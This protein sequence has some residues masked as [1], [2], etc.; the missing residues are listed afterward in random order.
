MA[1]PLA[2]GFCEWPVSEL[3]EEKKKKRKASRLGSGESGV[4]LI[5]AR[6]TSARH[7]CW[8][9]TKKGTKKNRDKGEERR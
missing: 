2:E 6:W 9:W 4:D 5:S 7:N 3:K 8:G 1:F